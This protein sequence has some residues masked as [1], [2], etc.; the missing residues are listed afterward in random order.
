VS[1]ALEWTTVSWTHPCRVC[2]GRGGCR[3][4]AFHGGFAVDCRNVVSAWPMTDGGWLHRRP[5]VGAADDPRHRA[6]GAACDFPVPSRCGALTPTAAGADGTTA[7]APGAS[8]TETVLGAFATPRMAE[9]AV[10][11]LL[12]AGFGAGE[13]SVLGRHDEA[14]AP[15]PRRG[16]TENRAA[17]AA[18]GAAVGGLTG[19]GIGYYM[20]RQ[21]KDM[22]Q[23]LARQ[24]RVEREG[25]TLRVAL[26]SDVLFDSGSARLQPGAEDKLRD[27]ARVLQQYP[28][29][30]IEI[31]GHTDSRGTEGS[32]Q[33]LSERRAAAVR[34]V[35][36]RD[37]VDPGRITVRGEGEMR[38]VATNDTPE[39]R[40]LNR[41]VELVTR[42]NA[43]LA[44]EGRREAPG[45]APP[46]P[47]EE[48]R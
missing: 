33:S 26:A 41:R 14:V 18:I 10:D 35:L 15:T 24:D 8:T 9:Q 1:D 32:N 20:D 13:L 21:K 5:A 45:G 42:P 17:R 46:A 48:P 12:A 2:G 44:A 23:V 28:R 39:G 38:P 16:T 22:E 27:I 47:A 37:G 3:T 19:G 4:A 31:V 6:E 43:S 36:V 30:D 34:D 7:A 29:T 25:E 11:A 40:A